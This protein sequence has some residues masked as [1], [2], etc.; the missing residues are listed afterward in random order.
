MPFLLISPPLLVM[1]M[2]PCA[3]QTVRT[4]LLHDFVEISGAMHAHV[5]A[6]VEKGDASELARLGVFRVSR[7]YAHKAA[8]LI[9][10]VH[11]S[12]VAGGTI[13][14]QS[15]YTEGLG[16]ILALAEA[17]SPPIVSAA[18]AGFLSVIAQVHMRGAREC[19]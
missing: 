12:N 17:P 15:E 13:A 5:V 8:A 16:A 4:G 2:R 3:V 9:K 10:A 11:D 1:R 18:R 14:L 6:V 19:G 7:C